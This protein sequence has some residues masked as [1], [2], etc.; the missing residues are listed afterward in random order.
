MKLNS[1]ETEPLGFRTCSLSPGLIFLPTFLPINPVPGFSGSAPTQVRTCRNSTNTALV[2]FA[3]ESVQTPLAR[4][5]F[6]CRTELRIRLMSGR[7]LPAS[8]RDVL[9]SGAANK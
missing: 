4:R 2:G 9:T 3:R 5:L 7:Q 6:S 8:R 1:A